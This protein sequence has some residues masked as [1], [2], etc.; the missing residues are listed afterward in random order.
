[1]KT[2]PDDASNDQTGNIPTGYYRRNNGML[3]MLP[4]ESPYKAQTALSDTQL[5]KL[6]NMTKEELI[7]LIRLCNAEQIGIALM[8]P[9]EVKAATRLRL[10]VMAISNKDDKVALQAIQQLLDRLEGKPLGTAQQ[11]NIGSNGGETRVQVILVDAEQYRK[12]Q[13][14]KRAIEAKVIDQ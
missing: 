8:T 9:D 13:A 11:I 10:A 5:A 7:A 2:L 6:D 3:H 1:M 14:A 12:E 4:V